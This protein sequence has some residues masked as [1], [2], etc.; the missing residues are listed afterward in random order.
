MTRSK[1]SS[2]SPKVNQVNFDYATLSEKARNAVSMVN[3]LNALR[4]DDLRDIAL[5][6][7][8]QCG[9]DTDLANFLLS[10]I[11][12]K[13]LIRTIYLSDNNLESIPVAIFEF[14][15]LKKLYL[16]DNQISN[17]AESYRFKVASLVD[18]DFSNNPLNQNSQNFLDELFIKKIQ[19][20]EVVKRKVNREDQFKERMDIYRYAQS[21][22][23][24][25]RNDE[26]IK[27]KAA[28]SEVINAEV[29]DILDQ[30]E[31]F[32]EDEN[33]KHKVLSD[34]LLSPI[35][36][37]KDVKKFE[38]EDVKKT[39]RNEVR[40]DSYEELNNKIAKINR[41]KCNIL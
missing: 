24:K 36:M 14:I 41:S 3:N 5:I 21:E 22:R 19:D 40:P 8:H 16:N 10:G 11:K 38:D 31:P 35:T 1:K 25:I 20:E 26:I 27:I 18:V 17:I 32:K 30:S 33:S 15:K 12:N 9:L 13:D 2:N 6:N 28:K 29:A 37:G 4:R 39:P 34:E 23:E 7:F